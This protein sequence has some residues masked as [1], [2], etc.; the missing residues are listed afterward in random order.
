[1]FDTH[2]P[3]IVGFGIEPEATTMQTHYTVFEQGEDGQ[4][5]KVRD[6]LGTLFFRD[7]HW[8][9]EMKGDVVQGELTGDPLTQHVFRD[10]AGREY[11]I[12]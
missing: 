3:S 12:T 7:G 10:T 11:R 2:A 5:T 4:L 1:V 8:E 6:V 9:L